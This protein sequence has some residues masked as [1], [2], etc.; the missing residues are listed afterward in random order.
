MLSSRLMR[1]GGLA[2]VVSGTLLV[3]ADL[4]HVL[5]GSSDDTYTGTI[6]EQISSVLFLVGMVLLIVA[7]VGLYLHHSEAAGTFGLIGFVIALIGTALM[8]SS[9]HL[10]T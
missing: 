2:A 10:A 9:A 7:L 5:M 6:P 3:M 1:V 8:V 4:L